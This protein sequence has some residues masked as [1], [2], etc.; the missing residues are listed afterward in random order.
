M[1]ILPEDNRHISPI[2][3][4]KLRTDVIGFIIWDSIIP[5][6]VTDDGG[7]AQ[8][9]FT[10]TVN[11]VDPVVEAGDDQMTDEGTEVSINATFTDA[12]WLD[13]HTVTIDWGDGTIEPG[14]VS[15]ETPSTPEIPVIPEP[16]AEPPELPNFPI[17]Y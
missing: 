1:H 16:P 4:H 7:V 10:V 8:D 17:V 9:T 14:N 15:E 2:R 12:G 5:P 13:I 3:P 6:T 11:N